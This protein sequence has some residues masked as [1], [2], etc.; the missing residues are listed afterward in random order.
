[1]GG[2]VGNEGELC[3]GLM[4]AL[5]RCGWTNGRLDELECWGRRLERNGVGGQSGD[6]SREGVDEKGGG[7]G[8]RKGWCGVTREGEHLD[9]MRMNEGKIC[10]DG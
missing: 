9:V 1:M 10:G 7:G 8:V 6:E 2:N 4:E 3:R 5:E